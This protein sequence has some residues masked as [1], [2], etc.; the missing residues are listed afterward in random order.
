MDD[1]VERTT[2]P[3]SNSREMTHIA[4]RQTTS[5]ENLGERH[6]RTAYNTETEI[7]VAP[8]DLD[9]SLVYPMRTALR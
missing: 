8:I 1:Q 2:I 4:C 3:E 6:N 5:T 9:R 7:G